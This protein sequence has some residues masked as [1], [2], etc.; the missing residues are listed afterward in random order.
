MEFTA[1]SIVNQRRNWVKN[2]T[3]HS[4]VL[5]VFV[6]KTEK[7]SQ[8]AEPALTRIFWRVKINFV[9]NIPFFATDG[10][11]EYH[12]ETKNVK[13]RPSGR[14][15]STRGFCA[16]FAFIS[17]FKEDPYEESWYYYGF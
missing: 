6:S 12:K 7:E 13:C 17:N 1:V 8:A 15:N 11:V 5:A 16:L 14:R 3:K 9:V 2:Y 10:N 4:C